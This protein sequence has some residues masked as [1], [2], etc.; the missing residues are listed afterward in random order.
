MK[1]FTI[2]ILDCSWIWRRNLWRLANSHKGPPRSE[3]CCFEWAGNKSQQF[4]DFRRIWLHRHIIAP[5]INCSDRSKERNQRK[6][7]TACRKTTESRKGVLWRKSSISKFRKLELHKDDVFWRICWN[8]HLW[9][10]QTFCS[11]RK[12]LWV[13]QNTIFCHSNF[14][15]V[16]ILL[17]G[18]QS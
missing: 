7:Q 17:G 12:L 2:L 11:Q 13:K 10:M 16:Q 6:K 18:L 4:D 14:R 9:S 8:R 5:K 15:T 3:H 1:L